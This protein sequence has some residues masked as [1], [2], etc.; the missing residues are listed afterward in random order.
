MS[1]IY[2]GNIKGEKGDN[3]ES[4]I[5]S[6]ATASVDDTTGTPSV[7]VTIGGRP[8][9]RTFDFAFSGLKGETGAEGRTT[10]IDV[11]KLT[12]TYTEASSLATTESGEAL[13]VAFGKIKKAISSLISHLSD[14][15]KHITAAERTSWNSIKDTYST[16]G[17]K[18]L[19]TQAINI[20][21]MTYENSVRTF[22][23]TQITGINVSS[24]SD[25]ILY[26][27]GT[28]TNNAPTTQF[29]PEKVTCY[30][31]F[32]DSESDLIS[33]GHGVEL[34]ITENHSSFATPISIKNELKNTLS[35]QAISYENG[36]RKSFSD[37]NKLLYYITASSSG[38]LGARF[39]DTENIFFKVQ[40]EMGKYSDIDI[41]GTVYV[42]GKEKFI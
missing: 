2:L 27:T 17:Y 38:I 22:Y 3:G 34:T 10:S 12:P 9:D 29:T 7:T 13:S 14:S 37:S 40:I 25:L 23:N 18:L 32:A 33:A 28:L 4:A 24:Y 30:I 41:S 1:K 21:G 8:N 5:I 11:N 36:V 39:H 16:D 6:G 20:E 19:K 26:F 42:Y 35:R 31:G 15:T